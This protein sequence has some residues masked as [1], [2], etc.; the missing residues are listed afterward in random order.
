MK[1]TRPMIRPLV[2]AL[3]Q[4][5]NEIIRRAGGLG[6]EM[7]PAANSGGWTLN[8]NGGAA[9]TVTQDANGIHFAAAN[10]IASV[11]KTAGG[12]VLEDNATYEVKFTVANFTGGGVRVLLGGN[13][14]NHGAT[15]TTRNANGTYTER[16]ALTGTFSSTNIIR[17]Q[18]TGANGTNTLDVTLIS[19]RKVT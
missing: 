1:L 4:L 16:L 9:G 14:L 15:G 6:P 7:A 13:T 5:P 3:S 2:R 11:S 12:L 17:I 19:V 8:L 18:V 10:N